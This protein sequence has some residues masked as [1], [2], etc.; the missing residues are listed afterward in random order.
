[1]WEK[2]KCF[3]LSIQK[4]L[5]ETPTSPKVSSPTWKCLVE[6]SEAVCVI[7]LPG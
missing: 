3:D 2:S 7:S 1:M 4:V 5:K 6:D